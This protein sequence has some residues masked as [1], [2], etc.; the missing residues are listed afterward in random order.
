MHILC[1][2]LIQALGT[3]Q[4][5]S[6]FTLYPH[7]VYTK[8]SNNAVQEGCGMGCTCT[9]EPTRAHTHPCSL[10][11]PVARN[12][13]RNLLFNTPCPS[14]IRWDRVNIVR[15]SI[16]VLLV[17]VLVLAE[18]RC[19]GTCHSGLAHRGPVAHVDCTGS[20]RRGEFHTAVHSTVYHSS[21]SWPARHGRV[22]CTP[23]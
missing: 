17:L 16:T 13:L 19:L 22:P 11:V 5:P 23:L 6:G 18:L 8:V 3:Q 2:A 9:L 14:V 7:G 20:G 10:N 21:H 12:K 15:S 4:K 1:Q